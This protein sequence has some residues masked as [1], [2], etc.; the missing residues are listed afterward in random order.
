MV[1]TTDYGGKNPNDAKSSTTLCGDD[2]TLMSE[3]SIECI[4]SLYAEYAKCNISLIKDPDNPKGFKFPK[5]GST[6]SFDGTT[7]QNFKT[8]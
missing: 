3:V 5:G 4:N 2:S 6:I 8:N 7:I 1:I